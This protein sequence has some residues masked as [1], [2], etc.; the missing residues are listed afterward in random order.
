MNNPIS[1]ILPQTRAVLCDTFKT[2]CDLFK[3]IVPVSIVTK[4]LK[5]AGVVDRMG[6]APG[7]VMGTVGLPGTMGLVWASALIVGVYSAMVVFAVL[8]PA[9]HLTVWSGACAAYQSRL[10][11]ETSS[12]LRQRVPPERTEWPS[13]G[14][15]EQ[16]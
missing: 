13:T 5:E 9:V 6:S 12:A 15:P 16:L 3:I 14:D 4:L 7:P 2:S 10:S 11:T 8:A 1:Q